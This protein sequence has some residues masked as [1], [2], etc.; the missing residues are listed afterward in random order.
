LI[1]G[2]SGVLSGFAL[3]GLLMGDVAASL[4]GLYGA[5][6]GGQLS[7]GRGWWLAGFGYEPARHLAGWRQ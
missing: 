5:Q 6:G 2:K 7:L 4:R 1:G 3:A